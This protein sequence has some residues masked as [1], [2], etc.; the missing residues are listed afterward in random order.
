MT[1]SWWV[2]SSP[3]PNTI[4]N[5]CLTPCSLSHVHFTERELGTHLKR[6]SK[7]AFSWGTG[8]V[9]PLEANKVRFIFVS[10]EERDL[11]GTNTKYL[12]FWPAVE[13]N[14]RGPS[15]HLEHRPIRTER[16]VNRC[17]NNGELMPWSSMTVPAYLFGCILKLGFRFAVIPGSLVDF[18][19]LPIPQ[20]K[21]ALSAWVY[22]NL[23]PVASSNPM[24]WEVVILKFESAWWAFALQNLD[25]VYRK[26][27]TEA[28][29]AVPQLFEAS[30]HM[31]VRPDRTT[32]HYYLI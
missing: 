2:T 23:G 8:P 1:H 16:R 29:F 21:S 3:F 17:G 26:R 28:S 10:R 19:H 9:C 15:C 13:G 7:S 30:V 6:P 12:V 27:R 32:T 31:W 5:S 14:E 24:V 22:H 11:T 18:H 4:S 25:N 20:F